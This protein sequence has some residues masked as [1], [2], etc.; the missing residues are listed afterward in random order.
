MNYVE[1]RVLK[2]MLA[3]EQFAIET[4]VGRM[5]KHNAMRRSDALSDFAKRCGQAN[6]NERRKRAAKK[7]QKPKPTNTKPKVIP[8]APAI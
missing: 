1:R 5:E 2:R 3:E 8:H 4:A 6:E 7:Q